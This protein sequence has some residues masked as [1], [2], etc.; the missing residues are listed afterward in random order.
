MGQRPRQSGSIISVC[1]S[2][3]PS[4]MPGLIRASTAMTN[5]RVGIVGAGYV[6]AHHLRAL[7]TLPSIQVVGVADLDLVRAKAVAKAFDLPDAFESAEELLASGVDVVHVLTPPAFHAAL[8]IQAL[9]AG[10]HVL[11]EKPMAETPEQCDRMI[12]A[13]HSSG[14]T[15]GVVHSARL[16][17]IVLRGVEIVRGGGIGQVLSIDFHRSSDYPDWPGGG[18]LPPQYR[19][20]SYPF[21]DIGVHGLA[22]AEAFLGQ[23]KSAEIDFRSCDLDSN[24]LFDEWTA[25]VN[26]ERGEARLYLS[27][28]VRPIRSQV[29]VHGTRGVMQIECFL[30]TCYVS[31]LLPG[32]KFASPV[33]CAMRNSAAS[34]YEVP[35]NVLRFLTKRL[36]GAPGIHQNIREFYT[37][38]EHGAATPVTPEEG[39]RLV[40]IMAPACAEADRQRD[41]LRKAQLT[42]RPPADVLV[43]GAGGFLG[44]ALLRRLVQ[45]GAKV[46]AGVRRIPK[47][48]LLG[49][50]YLA[51]DLGDP[52][53]V[54]NLVA[55][56]GAV[57]HVGAA[58]K[59]SPA[60]F[61]R[62]TVA[63]TRNVIDACLKYRV[64]RMVYVSSLSVL[65]HAGR[66]AG[67]VAE[68]WP[69]EPHAELRGA[70]TQTKL[71]AER[72]V[73]TAAK[74]QGLPAF[75][76]R[77]GVI[78]GPGV[79]PSCPAGS[80]AMFGRWIVV[81]SGSLPLPLVYVDD[82]VDALLL[83]LSQPALEG[84]LV[85]LID[86]TVV[87]QREFIHMAQ[88]AKPKIKASYVPK[89][90]LMAAAV[91][92][93]AL[94]RLLKR[95]VPLSRYRIRS[96]RPLS[97]FDQTA[98]R[99]QLGW[100]PRV[101]VADG[102][103][104]TFAVSQTTHPSLLLQ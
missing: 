86:P 18:K 6:S 89:P 62:G 92:I 41:A 28:N 35:R 71:E 61:Q 57:F 27:W 19:K 14:R 29:I 24:L 97:N 54:D 40:N 68:T 94:G 70:Y 63:G 76:I 103:R 2:G 32:P 82:V 13:A 98:A 101:G 95:G 21:Q 56:V 99:E 4:Q 45:E 7:K 85:N 12:A 37:A 26:C 67:K 65:E 11:V 9:Q 69:L 52:E 44:G 43:T 79:E 66:H 23:I 15:L 73:M 22:I 104:R 10:A 46:R 83:G 55:G 38:L 58:M 42:P 64:T 60:D 74:E 48:P 90:V 87:T 39:Q 59:G 102:L 96:I 80:F 17:P 30:Q 20:G 25:K 51:G 81:G 50:D 31:R 16:D 100:T 36:P 33:I 84:K 1:R 49:V 47:D 72:M 3:H 5:F 8:S 88:A 77:P 78:F 93:E 34:L 91:G 75:V 53:F